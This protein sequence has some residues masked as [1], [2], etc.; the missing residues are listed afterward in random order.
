STTTAEDRTPKYNSMQRTSKDVS[1]CASQQ[2]LLK[3]EH[4]NTTRCSTQVK[5]F[6][7]VPVNNY[8]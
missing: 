6:H 5:I 8:C 7:I 4:Q 3:I 2:L 1:Y